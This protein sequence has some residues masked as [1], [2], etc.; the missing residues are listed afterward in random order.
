MLSPL[1][2]TLN[3]NISRT[4]EGKGEIDLRRSR[5]SSSKKSNKPQSDLIGQGS[6]NEK[7]IYHN[8]EGLHLSVHAIFDFLSAY[9]SY[10]YS[11]F[12]YEY[13]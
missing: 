2:S 9:V 4:V 11:L 7:Y 13:L 8:I 12:R 1:I 10:F 6:S 3:F 5:S